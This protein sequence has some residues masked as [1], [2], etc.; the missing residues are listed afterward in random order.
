[1]P[2]RERRSSRAAVRFW[3]AVASFVLIGAGLVAVTPT[4]VAAQ[5]SVSAS[6]YVQSNVAKTADLSQFRPG[7]VV[8]DAVFFDSSTLT[9][10]QVQSF[11]ES[12]V[13][14][15]RSGYTC[16]KDYYV[17]TRSIAA[18]A[19]C[20]AYSGGG[21]ERA[22][23]VIVKVAQACGINPQVIIVMLQKEQG[24]VTSTAPS[25]WAYQAAMGQGCPDTAACDT[26]YYGLFNQVYGGAW[27]MKRYANPPGTSNYFTWYAPGNTW[28]VLFHPNSACGRAPVYIENQ[29]TANLYYY[30][31][32]QPNAA[33]LRAGYGEGDGCS[34]YGNRNFFN[35][36]TDWFGSTQVPSGPAFSS[37]DDS[38]YVLSLDETGAI[39]AHP[40]EK[41]SVGQP[42]EVASG[43]DPTARLLPIG[44]VD[45]D[46]H[47]DL[48]VVSD[49][50]VFLLR[51]D[52]R[53][54]SA[55]VPLDLDWGGSQTVTSA[56]DFDGDGTQDVFSVAE[57]GDL[58]LWRGTGTG[59]FRAPIVVGWGWSV[60]D[61]ISGGADM[62]GDGAVDVIARDTE[63]RLWA[64]YGRGDGRWAGRMQLGH[65]WSSMLD[66][67]SPGDFDGGGF[68]DVLALRANGALSL[69]RGRSDGS[70]TTGGSVWDDGFAVAAA[71]MG[72]TP[73]GLVAE[74]AGAGDLNGDGAADVVGLTDSGELR[75]YWGSGSGGWDGRGVLADFWDPADLVVAMGDFDGDGE[76]EIGRVDAEGALWLY[77]STG[78]GELGEGAQIG[79]GWRGVDMLVGGIDFDGD[80]NVDLLAHADNGDLRLY[81]GNGA[82]RWIAESRPTV[83]VKWG[84][85]DAIF[86]A[87]DFDGDGIGDILA[88]RIDDG[89]LWLYPTNGRGGWN[90][91]RR[92]GASWQD[93]TAVFSP[94]DFDGDGYVDVLAR[95]SAGD[96][97]LYRGNGRGGWLPWRG[98]GVRWD[99]MAQIV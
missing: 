81:R 94:G 68:A 90:P 20:G 79:V 9:E 43:V 64:Y 15:C 38:T 69:Y 11:L 72:A 17:Q 60:M 76:P 1:M 95:T 97:R 8:S 53:T 4:A 86:Y 6:T 10:A 73:R 75:G 57:N 98:V 2:V 30:T 99:V 87:G 71:A 49:G 29:A 16:L 18:D 52:G 23:R 83:G 22:S 12:K 70:I 55:R 46:D 89:S 5:D 37:L 66:V 82:G 51:G 50:G 92:V 33:A 13:S 47:R 28:N 31:P 48:V 40:Y 88:R 21:M 91:A 61:Y 39:W 32:Y 36:F 96:L 80:G 63:G 35:Y 45:G 67:F 25:S 54:F 77:S 62:N 14:S 56:G 34:S 19:M 26:R 84:V 59:R 85:M 44:D 58:Q 7:N 93:M 3:A 27:Q 42:V 65:G 41:S 78:S 74:H 24:L